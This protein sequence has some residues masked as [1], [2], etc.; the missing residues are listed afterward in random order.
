MSSICIR[1]LCLAMST[2]LVPW[3]YCLFDFRNKGTKLEH[4]KKLQGNL[5]FQQNKCHPEG[6]PNPWPAGPTMQPLTG[7]LRGDTLHEAI[8]GNPML[9]AS[10]GWTP[11]RAG[12]VARPVGNHLACY[13]FNQ[14]V[15]PSLDPINTP[16]RWKSKQH[17][18]LVV[19]YL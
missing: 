17:T 16:Y 8:E 4:F 9:K 11:W 13:L 3:F 1:W 15:N 2:N 7:W 5:K 12:H 6:V 19:L 14:V 10:V 18:L